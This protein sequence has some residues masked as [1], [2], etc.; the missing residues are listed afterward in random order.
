MHIMFFCYSCFAHTVVQCV[1]RTFLSVHSSIIHYGFCPKTVRC[2]GNCLIGHWEAS[3][4]ILIYGLEK[5]QRWPY[6]RSHN[7]LSPVRTK[8]Q[9]G[10]CA[11]TLSVATWHGKLLRVKGQDFLSLVYQINSRGHHAHTV[12]SL[13]FMS[14]QLSSTGFRVFIAISAVKDDKNK[15]KR[16][17]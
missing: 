7:T 8:S 1:I 14:V 2:D 12:Q 4:Y 5:A 11:L 13:Q 6:R 10:I 3:L 15:G 9:K 17:K 16:T